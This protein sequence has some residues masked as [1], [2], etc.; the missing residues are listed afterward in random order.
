MPRVVVGVI[1]PGAAASLD[2]CTLACELGAL[3]AREGW[4][5]LT[6]GRRE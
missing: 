2:D 6:G 5:L 3:V 1:G 4:V